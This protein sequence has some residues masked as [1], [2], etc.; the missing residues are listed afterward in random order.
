M[1]YLEEK[2]KISEN[3]VNQLKDDTSKL[4]ENKPTSHIE[5]ESLEDTIEETVDD[6]YIT[7]DPL[8]DDGCQFSMTPSGLSSD[9][10][11]SLVM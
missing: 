10:K 7:L 11:V 1:V 2:I 9:V 5:R 8:K 4:N 6:P 3:V